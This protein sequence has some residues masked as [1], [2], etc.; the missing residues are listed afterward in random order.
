MYLHL[1]GY[2]DVDDGLPGAALG[3]KEVQQFLKGLGPS[4]VAK[5]A[6]LS[7]LVD[8]PLVPQRVEMMGEGRGRDSELFLKLTDDET[9]WVRGQQQTDNGHT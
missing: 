9:C 4:S 1:G 7:L 6:P 8:E 3:V 2:G 5:K